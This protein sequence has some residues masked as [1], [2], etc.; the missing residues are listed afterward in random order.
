V[1]RALSPY[2]L[3]VKDQYAT[4]AEK[5]KLPTKDLMK[6]LSEAFKKLTDVQKAVSDVS[7]CISG[8]E[9]D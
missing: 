4:F 9:S 8:A 7:R 1:K 3:Y 2:A 5:H 6:V